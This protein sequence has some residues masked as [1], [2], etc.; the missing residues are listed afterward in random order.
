MLLVWNGIYGGDWSAFGA[1][2]A[3][4][5]GSVIAAAIILA[6]RVSILKIHSISTGK[7]FTALTKPDHPPRMA[8]PAAK[9]YEDD[10]DLQDI[11]E[12]IDVTSKNT[13]S[14]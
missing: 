14:V 6:L 3:A 8:E 1:F 9:G 5:V 4:P 11:Q 12:S 13:K 2:V 7:P 10:E